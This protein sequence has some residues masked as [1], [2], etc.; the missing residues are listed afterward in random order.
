MKYAKSYVNQIDINGFFFFCWLKMSM[1]NYHFLHGNCLVQTNEIMPL[2]LI[3][4]A[5]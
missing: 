4:V 1:R 3:Y 5:I 2:A